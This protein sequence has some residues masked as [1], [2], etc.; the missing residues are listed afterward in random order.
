[1]K[2]LTA[3]FTLAMTVVAAHATLPQPDLIAQIYFAG[4][5][6]ISAAANANAFA[7]E[8]CSIQALALRTQTADKLSAFLAGDRHFTIIFEPGPRR[9]LQGFFWGAGRLVLPILGPSDP[10]DCL[11]CLLPARHEV[12]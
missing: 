4:A 2:K 3:F 12:P 7:N 8:F 1:M 6:K 9:A 10:R 5:Q 11:C